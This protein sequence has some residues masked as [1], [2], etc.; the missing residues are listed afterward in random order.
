MRSKPGIFAQLKAALMNIVS[1]F[2]KEK[3][4]LRKC[5]QGDWRTAAAGRYAI[6][7]RSEG[8]AI[9][10]QFFVDG[11]PGG[12]SQHNFFRGPGDGFKNGRPP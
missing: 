12:D 6:Q 7:K 8:I 10:I 4:F 3:V 2:Q 11:V 5:L 9:W 1:F